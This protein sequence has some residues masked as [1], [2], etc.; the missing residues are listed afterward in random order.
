MSRLVLYTLMSL[1]GGVDNPRAY[2]PDNGTR[3]GPPVFDRQLI[4][5]EAEMIERQEAVLLGRRMYD[6]WSRYWPTSDEQPFA[7]FIN[8][9]PKHVLTSS[10]LTGSWAGAEPIT[11]PLAHAVATLKS[12]YSGDVGVHG[13]ITLARSLLQAGLVDEICL[14]VGRVI[15]PLGG[16][17]F[18][19][20]KELRTLQLL[21]A[22]PTPSGSLWLRYQTDQGTE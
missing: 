3:S 11:A 13:S 16:R 2:F 22:T 15:D 17:L 20:I 8:S 7:D 6:E 5:L 21:Q 12:R 1:D 14:A 19:G 4:D 9:V 18:T 10:R